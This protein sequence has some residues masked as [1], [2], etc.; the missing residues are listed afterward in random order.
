MTERERDIDDIDFDF[1]DEPETEEATQR[2]PRVVPRPQGPR[3]GGGG[4]RPPRRAIRPAQGLAP[5]LR[6]TGLIAFAILIVILVVFGVRRCSASSKANEYRS[7]MGDISK[8]ATASDELGQELS[9]KLTTPGIKERDLE[10]ALNGLA[11]QQQQDLSRA[12]AIVP[13]GPLRPEHR[14]VIDALQLRAS[15]LSRLRDAFHQTA[16]SKE[17]GRA[18][19]LLAEQGR[20]LTASDVIWDVYFL[21]PARAELKKQGIGGVDV[22]DS[23]FVSNPD[24]VSRE[25]MVHVFQR[26][27]GAA[28]G[29][30][31]SGLHGP[32]SSP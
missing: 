30:T 29:G 1:F 11:Q 22:P 31:P 3:P 2:R 23:R 20:L 19:D 17:A 25:G 24:I 16:D 9:D 26:I 14:H 10:T 5:L 28:T 15:G 18:G 21:E 32:G 8:L 4:G 6:L 7:Y 27:R 13:P 12:Q